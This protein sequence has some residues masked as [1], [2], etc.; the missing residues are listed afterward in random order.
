M[1]LSITQPY[2]GEAGSVCHVVIEENN[3]E[4]WEIVGD[5]YNMAAAN[6]LRNLVDNWNNDQASYER[7]AKKGTDNG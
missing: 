7:L 1:K 2:H 3:E 6:H 4:D 5:I